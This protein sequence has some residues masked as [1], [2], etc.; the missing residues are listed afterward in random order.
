MSQLTKQM[1]RAFMVVTIFACFLGYPK[2]A[3]AHGT[4]PPYV[5][6][7]DEYAL[8]NPIL[9]IA[10]PT[11]FSVGLDVATSSGYLVGQPI[12]FTIDEQFFP[13]PYGAPATDGSGVSPQ[14]QWNFADGTDKVEGKKIVHVFAKPGTYIVQLAVKFP[15]NTEE[16]VQVD[17]IQ[18]SILPSKDYQIPTAQ[19]RVNGKH[20]NEPLRDVTEIQPVTSITFDGSGST[21][22][23]INYQWDFGDNKG[24]NKSIVMHRYGRD[25]YFPVVVLRVTDENHIMVDTYALLDMPVQSSNPFLSLFYSISD[26]VT[27]FLYKE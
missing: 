3:S 12:T 4:G 23:G 26:F 15:G 25:E 1:V 22:N 27:G 6:I 13:N 16:F 7:N 19:I 14:F 10:P 17:T 9:N 18:M 20:V 21:G 24:A 8:G 11:K 2:G 5:Q